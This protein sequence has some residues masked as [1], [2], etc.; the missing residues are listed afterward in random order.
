MLW[1][2]TKYTHDLLSTQKVVFV[3][4]MTCVEKYLGHGKRFGVFS[5]TLVLFGVTFLLNEA[6]I[7]I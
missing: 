2:Q 1:G 3:V 6:R 7:L 4:I 5:Y